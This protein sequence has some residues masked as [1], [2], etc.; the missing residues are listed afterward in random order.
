[1]QCH[2]AQAFLSALNLLSSQLRK[3]A[4]SRG[5][6]CPM[7]YQSLHE[8]VGALVGWLTDTAKNLDDNDFMQGSNNVWDG[9]EIL[10]MFSDKLQLSPSSLDMFVEHFKQI[11]AA[12]EE[13]ERQAFLDN[14]DDNS[15]KPSYINVSYDEENN[16]NDEE[17]TE[18]VGGSTTRGM[19]KKGALAIF[20]LQLLKDLFR[21]FEYMLRNNAECI[22][23]YKL[24]VLKNKRGRDSDI[25]LNFW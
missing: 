17:D 20:S 3:G 4:S 1:M 16:V 24:V 9:A 14:R 13:D 15:S 6:G 5:C 25:T 2:A 8:M 10:A 12:E 7:S 19:K 22:D 21:I 18:L 23:S 11:V